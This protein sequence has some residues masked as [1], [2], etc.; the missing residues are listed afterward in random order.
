MENTLSQTQDHAFL[1]GGGEMGERLARLDWSGTT[2]GPIEGWSQSLRA[3]IGLLLRSPLP[4]VLLWGEAGTMVYNQA[5][6]GFAG[7]RHPAILGMP[8]R[9]AWPEAA[10]F[11][12]HVMRTCLTGGTLQYT[13]RPITLYRHGV[14]EQVWLNLHYSPVFDDDARPA[15]VIAF[16]VETTATVLAQERLRESEA[17]FRGFAQAMPNHVWTARPDGAL[18]WLND[19]VIAY[20]GQPAEQLLGQGWADMVHPEDIARAAHRWRSAIAGGHTYETQFRLRR[21]DGAWRWHIARALPIRGPDGVIIRWIGSNTDI[22]AQKVAEAALAELNATLE[23]QVAAR[24][25]ER[26]RMWRLS[27]DLMIVADFGVGIVAVN[28]AW[29]AML[30]WPQAALVGRSV[31]EFIHPDDHAATAAEA[32]RLAQ[33][34][35]TVRFECRFRAQNGEYR[36]I[37]WTAVPDESFIHAVG[38]DI[39]AEREAAAALQASEVALQQAQKMETIGNLTGGV[40]HDFNN[41]LQVISANLELLAEETKPEPRSH[42]LLRHAMEAVGRGAKLASQL[43]AYARRQPLAP[44]VV[45]IG[46]LIRGMDDMLRRTLGEAVEVE[47]VIAGG[48]WNSVVDPGQIENA[49]LNLAIN[50]RDAMAGAGRLTIEAG[51][52]SLDD[53]YCRQQSDV[54]P[55]Q[56]VMLAVTDTGSGMSPEIIARVFEP[57]F[58]TKPE[59]QGTGLGLSMVYGFVKQSGGHVKIYS[60]PGLGTTVRLYLPRSLQAEDLESRPDQGPVQGGQETILL[61]EDD[62]NVLAA[63]AAML[64]GLG[65]SVLT[66]R[67]AAAA[68]AVIESGAAVDL[69]FTDVVMPGAMKST[70]LATRARARLPRV[71]VLFTSGYTDNAIVHG[72]RLDAGVELLSKPY[73]RDALARKLRQMLDAARPSAQR[74]ILLVEDDAII[75][76]GSTSLLRRMGHAVVPAADAED[77]LRRLAAEPG[78]DVLFTDIGLPGISGVELAVRAR[79]LRPGLPVIFASGY[80]EVPALAGSAHV[81]KPYGKAEIGRALAALGLTEK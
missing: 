34:I 13:D 64:Q 42:A 26:D 27:T 62:P 47:I 21:H 18:D 76:L 49:L 80:N 69:L 37:S 19:R 36:L 78:I 10:D 11:N 45:N 5:Y 24:T 75:R 58:S 33:G 55:G 71:A 56:Y 59:G 17:Q 65:Y 52:A 66:A 73:T 31:L 81:G 68:L 1:T 9:D 23:S 3:A 61:A 48:L 40:A 35:P 70:E 39:T 67:D 60:E 46:R 8:V 43:L 74:H 25:L 22:E 30:G 20:A 51:N 38:R 15:G 29:Q 6:A 14:A 50:G 7:A 44:K 72:G 57:F 41:L 32:G 54:Q 53:D 77:A 12:D 28:P 4:I 2:M 63:A 16:V 79:A